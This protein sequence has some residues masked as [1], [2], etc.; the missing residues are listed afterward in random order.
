MGQG[1]I[2]CYLLSVPL[3]GHIVYSKSPQIKNSVFANQAVQFLARKKVFQTEAVLFLLCHMSN[4]SILQ[5]FSN[6][7]TFCHAMSLDNSRNRAPQLKKIIFV[8]S[9]SCNLTV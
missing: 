9:F 4:S 1:T 3:S 6:K 7:E 8:N 2:N 5:S